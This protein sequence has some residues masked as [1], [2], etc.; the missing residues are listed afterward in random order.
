M[1]RSRMIAFRWL[2]DCS[3]RSSSASRSSSS[4][5]L[6]VKSSLSLPTRCFE[7]ASSRSLSASRPSSVWMRYSL[8]SCSSFSLKDQPAQRRWWR[9][10][11]DDDGSAGE[12]AAEA[13]GAAVAV[14]RR[15]RQA[16][17]RRRGRRHHLGRGA[18]GG[19]ADTGAGDVRPIVGWLGSSSRPA[20]S[21]H[22][23]QS[24]VQQVLHR[25]QLKGS[26]DQAPSMIP[27]APC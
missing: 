26:Y 25:T 17:V 18:A 4:L 7:S 6:Y 20:T 8:M 11:E 21:P 1:S 5:R 15:R 16:E 27:C 19:H 14:E 3:Y 22:S 2:N 12:P 23:L 24:Y 10:A 13:G 9:A